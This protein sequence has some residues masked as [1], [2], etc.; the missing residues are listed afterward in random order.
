MLKY[1]V[2][3]TYSAQ[4]RPFLVDNEPCQALSLSI[5]CNPSFHN[6]EIPHQVYVHHDTVTTTTLSL[7]MLFIMVDIPTKSHRQGGM[8][9]N[10]HPIRVPEPLFRKSGNPSQQIKSTDPHDDYE[11]VAETLCTLD[12]LFS[13]FDN[14][15]KSPTLTFATQYPSH[16]RPL[17][18]MIF[19]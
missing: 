9:L 18:T 2:I 7:D 5:S 16:R 3:T 10:I 1:I 11:P 14:P 12:M 17:G 8:K 6:N 4:I 15:T 19:I 13:V